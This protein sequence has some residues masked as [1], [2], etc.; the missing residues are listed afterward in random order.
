MLVAVSVMLIGGCSAE[1]RYRVL[2]LFF[3]GV[4]DP[5]APPGSRRGGYDENGNPKLYQYPLNAL[6]FTVGEQFFNSYPYNLATAFQLLGSWHLEFTNPNSL[7]TPSSADTPTIIGAAIL[8]F[9]NSVTIS[10]SGNAPRFDWTIP[11]GYGID[12]SQILIW[13]LETHDLIATQLNTGT[14]Y[15]VPPSL[16]LQ[17]NHRY[18][19]QITLVDLRNLAVAAF[20]ANILSQSR[21]FFD[22]TLLPAGSPPQVTLPTPCAGTTTIEARGRM[23][24]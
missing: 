2:S 22:F 14:S 17:Q 12:Q 16:N 3:D 18:S 23:G 19:I 6:V 24:Q 7:Y 8:P 21:S 20:P 9:A 11:S 5:N 15:Q 1:R 13:D 10:G 4:P